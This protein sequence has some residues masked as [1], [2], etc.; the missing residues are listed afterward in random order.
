[1]AEAHALPPLAEALR[2]VHVP[3]EGDD[4]V[5]L[6]R[7]RT[8]AWRR[9]VFGE[10]FTFQVGMALR[11]RRHRGGSAPG[12]SGRGEG[13]RRFLDGL[14]FA[15][16]GA[17][18]RVIEELRR[19]LAG[20]AP[21]NRLVQGDVGSGK[22]VVALAAACLV[23][24]AGHQTALMVPTEL[25]AEQHSR[26]V[27]RVLEPAGLS[28]A[29]L[30]GSLRRRA[31]EGVLRGLLA[32][33]VDLV[34]G[35]HALVQEGVAFRSLGLAVVDEQH[36]FGVRQRL[37]LREKGRDPHVVVM[38]ATPIPRSLSLTLY[39]DLDVSVIDELPPGRG[40]VRTLVV[41][42]SDRGSVYEA[43]R[44]DLLDGAQAFF[45]YP[46]VEET[47]DGG[48]RAAT[49]MAERLRDGPLA[50]L[51]VGLVHGR[52]PP[53]Q[54]DEVMA[55][56]VAGEVRALV[57]T[58][59]V[60]VGVD[61]PA[62]TV[63][64]VEHAE[65]FG[66]AQL[67]QLRGR[68]G[69]G[70]D[71]RPATCYLVAAEETT[72]AADDRLSVLASTDDGFAIADAD[73]LQRGPGEFVGTR[74]SGLPHFEVADLLRDGE[75]LRAARQAA[76]DLVREDPELEGHPQVWAAVREVW[77]GNLELVDVG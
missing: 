27:E 64:V 44:R 49:E 61:V 17:Q 73:L 9:L 3:G 39:G 41:R 4:P 70:G 50:G 33:S 53:D 58:T 34:V 15:L 8:A 16:T 21:A 36:R 23:A 72:E 7:R 56:F 67:H 46:A 45:V 2:R 55:G 75:V 60:E 48:L 28:V 37:S 11:R 38:T 74:Q 77:A 10:L 68:I 52:L 32:G 54:R 6:T 18:E 25:L 20:S 57:A 14:P 76:F 29:L 19:D 43:A 66:L 40:A 24:E 51:E 47:E 63:M 30:T 1:V 12:C 71:G 22:T 42:D 69:R 13:L 26:T 35:T 31:R 65:R 62:A 5:E 59:V